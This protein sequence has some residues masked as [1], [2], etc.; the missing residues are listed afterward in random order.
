MIMEILYTLFGG[1]SVMGWI[2]FITMFFKYRRLALIAGEY[3]KLVVNAIHENEESGTLSIDVVFLMAHS[4]DH[5]SVLTGLL[6]K[7]F[8]I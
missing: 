2:G 5:I 7:L 6:G 8:R 1:L 3:A 4:M